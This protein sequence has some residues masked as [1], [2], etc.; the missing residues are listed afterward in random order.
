MIAR[1]ESLKEEA[2]NDLPGEDVKGSIVV[3]LNN[4]ITVSRATLR[5]LPI[6]GAERIWASPRDTI[7]N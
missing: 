6:D 3:N 1:R 7:L 5:T 2:L 4:I